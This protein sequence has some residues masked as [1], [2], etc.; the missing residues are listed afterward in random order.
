MSTT[1]DLRYGY[2][3]A[4]R[5]AVIVSEGYCSGCH[6]VKAADDA[7]SCQ[8]C[9][10]SLIDVHER[11]ILPQELEAGAAQPASPETT[12]DSG[13]AAAVGSPAVGRSIDVPP[14]PPPPPSRDYVPTGP[15]P[16]GAAVPAR[17]GRAPLT[18][19]GM[20]APALTY[21][22]GMGYRSVL[23]P[24]LSGFSWGAFLLHWIW[25]VGNR[26]YVALWFIPIT[27][28]TVGLGA[29]PFMI[30]LGVKGNERAWRGKA[31]ESVERF[32]EVQRKWTIAALIVAGVLGVLW[33]A[34]AVLA[35]L[36][37]M[38]ETASTVGTVCSGLT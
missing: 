15:E 28:L 32:R 12:G 35:I 9:G 18:V 19:P 34:T 6:E 22:P 8:T 1:T 20:A 5:G 17:G 3:M 7:G 36:Q 2:E 38:T 27:I 23:P 31:W 13:S 25:G 4:K 29:L 30:W 21:E 26:V 10:G 14:P 16:D 37:A 11:F 24:E 33:I